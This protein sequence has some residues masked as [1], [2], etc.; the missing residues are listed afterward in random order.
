[1]VNP[2]NPNQIDLKTNPQGVVTVFYRFTVPP[3]VPST[4]PNVTDVTVTALISASIGSSTA[5]WR[6]DITVQKC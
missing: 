5:V 4:D 6:Y 3:C 2:G 1:M